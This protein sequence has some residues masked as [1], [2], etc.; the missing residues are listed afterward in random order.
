MIYTS[1][2]RNAFLKIDLAKHPEIRPATESYALLLAESCQEI[3]ATTWGL[4]ESGAA[5]PTGSRYG[6]DLGHTCIAISGP[7]KLTKTFESRIQD[8]EANM[9][10]FAEQALKLFE[11]VLR[12]S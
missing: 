12:R 8:R 9:Q 11:L 4:S 5:G 3:L 2:A 10:L 6:D 7:S 1:S